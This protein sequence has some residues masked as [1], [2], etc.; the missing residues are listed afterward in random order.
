M[1]DI[2]FG[3]DYG[4]L[5]E[6]YSFTCELNNAEG[7]LTVTSSELSVSGSSIET[8]SSATT[9]LHVSLGGACTPRPSNRANDLLHEG[10]R[11]LCAWLYRCPRNESVTKKV[12]LPIS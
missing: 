12:P 8:G 10:V 6:S 5:D 2:S 4:I 3:S 11:L 1:T 9:F 7:S